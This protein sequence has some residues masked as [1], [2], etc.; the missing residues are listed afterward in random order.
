[1]KFVLP[2]LALFALLLTGPSGTALAQP[3]TPLV[4]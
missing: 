2:G 3:S 1:M 4:P